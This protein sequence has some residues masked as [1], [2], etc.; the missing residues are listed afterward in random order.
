M[1]RDLEKDAN[2]TSAIKKKIKLKTST[3]MDQLPRDTILYA[4]SF[5]QPHEVWKIQATCK[6]FRKAWIDRQG[7]DRNPVDLR[8]SSPELLEQ[9][10]GQCNYLT[11]LHSLA[12]FKEITLWAA[13][14]IN[15]ILLDRAGAV[16]ADTL[17]DSAGAI[18]ADTLQDRAGAMFA[19][20]LQVAAHDFAMFFCGITALYIAAQF[21]E[22]EIGALKI[23]KHFSDTLSKKFILYIDELSYSWLGCNIMPKQNIY[24][25]SCMLIK[26]ATRNISSA[27]I[28]E[29]LTDLTMF[30]MEMYNSGLVRQGSLTLQLQTKWKL[31]VAICLFAAIKVL[32]IAE[33]LESYFLP[34][35]P[36]D[37]S[38][39]RQMNWTQDLI[40]VSGGFTKS[41]LE[42]Y[43]EQIMDELLIQPEISPGKR[44]DII[45]KYQRKQINVPEYVRSALSLLNSEQ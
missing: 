3:T 11:R 8:F 13:V 31:F 38:T 37:M 28:R 24:S 26:I 18:F 30:I 45:L 22:Q 21:L 35:S 36:S 16:F 40:E 9:R 29:M 7:I 2:S 32:K 23:T 41:D 10:E 33:R 14:Y 43:F 17:Q 4:L 25:I 1:K 19:D 20:T 34:V 42:P 6:T 27:S 12:E 5:L 44:K 39:L 15:D